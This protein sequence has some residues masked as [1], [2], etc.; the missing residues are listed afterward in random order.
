[1]SVSRLFMIGTAVLGI[2]AV[3]FRGRRMRKHAVD[4]LGD[5]LERHRRVGDELPFA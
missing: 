1:M 2:A 3:A 4:R 5:L